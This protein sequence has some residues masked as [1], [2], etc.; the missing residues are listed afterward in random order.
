LV[1]NSHIGKSANFKYLIL[2]YY[3]NGETMKTNSK[4]WK[5]WESGWKYKGDIRDPQ[6]LKD[7]NKLF[8]ENGNG[9]W[10]YQGFHIWKHSA[11]N[12]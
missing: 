1:V 2:R 3:Y 9:W 7:R 12:K 10:W 5:E 8:K 6:Y 11:I 4:D